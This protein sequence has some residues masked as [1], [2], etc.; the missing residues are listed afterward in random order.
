MK[1]ISW[2]LFFLLGFGSVLQ[3]QQGLKL[4]GFLLP[5]A[6]VLLNSQDQSLDDD[7]YR[8]AILDAMAVGVSF[9]YDFNDYIGFRLNPQYSLQGGKYTDRR[10]IDTRNS[11]VTRL[12]YLKVPLLLHFNSNPV[13]HKTVF[14]FEVG[15]S[16]GLLTRAR[17][18]DDNPA[19]N[20]GLPD[21]ISDFPSVR[22]TFMP[23]TVNL[24]GGIGFDVR[25]D[26]DMQLNL[27]LVGDYSLQDVEDKGATYRLTQDGIT[28]RQPYW[29]LARGAT[30]NVETYGIT[31]GLM[32]GITWLFP[33][34]GE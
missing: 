25:L 14:V 26:Y 12:E 32:I 18:Y 33:T 3:A 2:F 15:A 34:A 8:L 24:T 20:P 30:R 7:V 19:F 28:S 23:F 22:E 1:K 29:D 16:I 5:Q 6:S 17:M 21:N 31:G 13:N 27:R 4:G 9:G 10:D 11:Y